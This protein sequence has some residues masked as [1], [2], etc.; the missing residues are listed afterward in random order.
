[1][2]FNFLTKSRRRRIFKPRKRKNLAKEELQERA[3]IA[4]GAPER[5]GDNR[6]P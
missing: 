2:I 6:D 1:M 4:R 3:A 5:D